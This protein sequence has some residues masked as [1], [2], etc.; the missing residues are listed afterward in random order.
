[1]L[2]LYRFEGATCAA[3]VLFA[4][5]EKNIAFEDA[6]IDRHELTAPWYLALNPNG[7][8]PTIVHD[9]NVIIES[10]VILNYLDDAFEG[11][12]LRPADPVRK[13]RMNYWMKVMDDMLNHL[14][15]ATYAM[16]LRQSYLALSKEKLEQYYA[17]IPDYD[18]RERRRDI[19]EN[20]LES[21]SVRSS[22]VELMK[23]QA[24][25]DADLAGKEYLCS[26]FS[27]ADISLAAFAWRLEPLGLL[28]TGNRPNLGAWWNR[29]QARPA[30]AAIRTSAPPQLTEGLRMAGQLHGE[31]VSR[32]C[33]AA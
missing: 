21:P 12:P 8:V 3:K 16:A 25:A 1:M 28:D 24:M 19:V 15:A 2:K 27:I 33:R 20:G 31:A 23:F 9:G 32:I 5:E 7:V 29:T 6:V 11:H 4:L 18:R 14:G 10:T 22:I 13:A 26:D 30:F 17:A